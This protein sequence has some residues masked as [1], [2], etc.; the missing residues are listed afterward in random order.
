MAFGRRS[1]ITGDEAVVAQSTSSKLGEEMQWFYDQVRTF[2]GKVTDEAIAKVEAEI[3]ERHICHLVDICTLFGWAKGTHTELRNKLSH[4]SYV[5]LMNNN[6]QADTATILF[7]AMKRGLKDDYK[8]PVDLVLS[9]KESRK[10]RKL[11]KSLEKNDIDLAK[12]LRLPKT[13]D[14]KAASRKKRQE[15]R[16]AAKAAGLSTADYKAKIEKAS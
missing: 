7:S 10:A 5:I 14:A 3:E 4:L 8:D 1:R 2:R 9:K 6:G 11:R 16:K 12:K 13:D 15:I